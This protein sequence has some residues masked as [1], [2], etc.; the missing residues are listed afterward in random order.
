[1]VGLVQPCCW[2]GRGKPCSPRPLIVE[3]GQPGAEQPHGSKVDGVK[4]ALTTSSPAVQILLMT[5]AMIWSN[6]ES[7]SA[8]PWPIVMDFLSPT[9]APPTTAFSASFVGDFEPSL[10]QIPLA[11][12]RHAMRKDR[13]L[14]AAGRTYD[15]GRAT[16]SLRTGP[17]HYLEP[18]RTMRTEEGFRVENGLL[19]WVLSPL[20]LLFSGSV[21]HD[22]GK[23]V[24]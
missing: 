17:G 20:W 7:I 6:T 10:D 16:E 12:R 14:P 2:T 1:M 3:N 5:A 23:R 4:A 21:Q 18:R 19:C 11:P 15:A 22:S 8:A 24:Y 13:H 9:L